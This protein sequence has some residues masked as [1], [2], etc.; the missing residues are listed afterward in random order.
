MFADVFEVKKLNAPLF[1]FPLESVVDFEGGVSSNEVVPPLE[2]VA[3]SLVSVAVA[4]TTRS[5][6][7]NSRS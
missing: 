2:A 1:G 7:L 5:A 3:V 4:I 6:S